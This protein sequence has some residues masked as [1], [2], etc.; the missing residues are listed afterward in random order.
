MATPRNVLNTAISTLKLMTVEPYL[1]FIFFGHDVRLVTFQSL[2]TKSSCRNL[3]LFSDDV[4]DN[5]DNH[6]SHQEIAIEAANNL[7]ASIM[8]I[9]S[10]P[11]VFV[12]IFL[13]P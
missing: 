4:G 6:K 3:H 2:L 5:L 1:F 13:G 10:L 8:L 12:S 7:Y 11:A 9:S